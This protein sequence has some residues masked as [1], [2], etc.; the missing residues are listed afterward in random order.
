MQKISLKD[1][2]NAVAN[3]NIDET[4]D[5]T[6]QALDEGI[7]P[8]TVINEGLVAGL[9]LVGEQFE[10]GTS[11][12]PELLLSAIAGKAG[13]ELVT[14]DLRKSNY[15][16]KGTM[17]L[18]TVAGDVHDIG[19]DL[20][21]TILESNGYNVVNLGVDVSPEKFVTAIKDYKPEFLGMSCLISTCMPAMKTT[22]DAVVDA[23]LRN[24]L[25]IVIGGAPVTQEYASQIGADGYALDAYK[26]VKL[27]D[28]WIGEN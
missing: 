26:G 8:M 20:V 1:I 16:P 14:E 27:L 22:I 3:G 9:K 21:A 15:T 19:K 11:F 6:R 24:G 12:L 25:R 4:R 23:G 10:N 13:I 17:V 7:A 5:L 28:G 18:G 2:I